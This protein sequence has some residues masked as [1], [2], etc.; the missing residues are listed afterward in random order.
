[1]KT[2]SHARGA[3]AARE[4]GR[5]RSRGT[6]VIL[7]CVLGLVLAAAAASTA[8]GGPGS[9]AGRDVG[10]PAR[11]VQPIPWN[12]LFY[13]SVD[14]ATA[15][16]G[17]YCGYNL[18][19]GGWTIWKS[20]DGGTSWRRQRYVNDLRSGMSMLQLRALTSRTCWAFDEHR[21]FRTRNGGAN[22]KLVHSTAMTLVDVCFVD[23]ARAY[24]TAVGRKGVGYIL[25]STNGGDTWTTVKRAGGMYQYSFGSID[26]VG[27]KRGWVMRGPQVL[28]TTNGGQSWKQC[29]AVA[30]D[31]G[32]DVDFVSP[33]VGWVVGLRGVWKSVDGGAGWT[34]QE[35]GY[36]NVGGLLQMQSPTAG[37][38]L[39]AAGERRSARMPGPRFSPWSVN[40]TTDGG[41]S[42]QRVDI[43]DLLSFDV[44]G[45]D[46]WALCK[47]DLVPGYILKSTDGGGSWKQL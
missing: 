39:G 37:W 20:G 47:N 34:Q 5:S 4:R 13:G 1:M 46:C 17:W 8:A 10:E 45:A 41:A 19:A 27:A 24:A 33:S 11:A 15:S 31:T 30:L 26:F 23:T 38:W 36:W 21:I 7:A 3:V 22:W 25:K 14:F 16:S 35:A 42:W 29:A 40:R 9:A 43:P 12:W 32:W 6:Q 2:C 28:R 44:Q 18:E